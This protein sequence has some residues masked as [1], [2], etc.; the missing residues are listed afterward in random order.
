VIT[1]EIEKVDGSLL[2]T[3][4]HN[5][6]DFCTLIRF[7][8]K[9]LKIFNNPDYRGEFSTPEDEKCPQKIEPGQLPNG[10][11]LPNTNRQQVAIAE[12][13]S[14]IAGEIDDIYT[15]DTIQVPPKKDSDVGVI[16][17]PE[18]T[19]LPE[20]SPPNVSPEEQKTPYDVVEYT[21]GVGETDPEEIP[22]FD[23]P[24]G[25][26]IYRLDFKKMVIRLEIKP[27]SIKVA[28][29]IM[30][31]CEEEDLDMRLTKGRKYVTIRIVRKEDTE[32]G[33]VMKN[34]ENA[35]YLEDKKPR[36][37]KK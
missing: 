14:S 20:I 32:Y 10:G 35:L 15:M 17:I 16:N 22:L 11:L 4:K 23:T 28:E 37:S 33:D 5:K 7:E 31:I 18:F 34:I 24:R 9:H 12:T 19:Q 29:K 27:E 25:D 21:E 3:V 8:E 30:S 26:K 1:L 13:T 6:F 36:L 2:I